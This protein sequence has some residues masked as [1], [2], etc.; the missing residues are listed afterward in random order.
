MKNTNEKPST[1]EISF[2]V[3]GAVDQ[4]STPIC[5]MSIRKHFP[6]SQIIL[7][8]W[9]GSNTTGLDYDKVIVN[10]DPGGFVDKKNKRCYNN[11][12]RQIV[13][14]FNGL[15]EVQTEYAVK[16][17]SDLM[18]TSNRFVKFFG[19]YQRR[20]EDFKIF[21]N[22][23]IT[24]CFT[25]K[26]S[27]GM[28]IT[29]FCISDWFYFGKS[30]DLVKLFDIPLNPDENDLYFNELFPDNAPK[31]GTFSSKPLRYFP[32]QY[33]GYAKFSQYYPEVHFGHRFCNDDEIVDISNHFISNNFLMLS[34]F[35]LP[36]YLLKNNRCEYFGSDY[37]YWKRAI[38][39]FQWEELYKKYCCPDHI[40]NV[41]KKALYVYW[42]KSIYKYSFIQNALRSRYSKITEP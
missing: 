27:L 12:N 21:E 2:V 7:S 36:V 23:I 29:P 24:Y 22:R 33:I 41:F 28:E 10:K 42:V 37:S 40:A 20:T 38:N 14:S 35:Q 18:L 6:A 3:Q 34:H 31:H 26:F 25:S 30:S 1:K 16:I 32:E 4:E 11:V 39:F 19:K 15:K 17:R 13:S 9:E 8:T 5:I